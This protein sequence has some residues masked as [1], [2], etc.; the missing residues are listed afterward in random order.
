L[1]KFENFG[2]SS[3]SS[4]FVAHSDDFNKLWHEQFGHLNYF[5]LLQLCNQQM[6]IGLPLISC[7]YGVC[8]GCVLGKH[9]WDSFDKR[10]SWNA[11]GPLQLVH[12]DLCG[13][14]FSPFFFLGAII[15]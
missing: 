2:S 5:S 10:A 6:V 7:I 14:L 3:F 1:Y 8:A 12:I 4:V 11:S 9:Y 15:S 13:L